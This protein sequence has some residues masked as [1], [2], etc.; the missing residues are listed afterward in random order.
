MVAASQMMTL[1]KL[2]LLMVGDLVEEDDQQWT[3]FFLSW[4]IHS[5]VLAYTVLPSDSVR[6]A[7]V[8]DT[9]LELFASLYGAHRSYQR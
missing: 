6:L 7:W 1:M 8:V 4:D 9:Y 5:M 3:C 2:Y